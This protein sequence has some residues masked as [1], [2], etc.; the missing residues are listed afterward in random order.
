MEDDRLSHEA[1][2]FKYKL[3][4]YYQQTVMY[5]ITLI[6]YAGVR[7]TFTFERL[8]S[9]GADPLLYIIML[10]VII[11]IVG[12]VLNSAR[13]RKLII[14]KDKIIFHNKFHERSI[15]VSNIEWMHVGRERTVRTAG[16][17][18]IVIFKIKDRRR[19][20]RIRVGR[21]EREKELIAEMNR[22]AEQIPRPKRP[23]FGI[24]SQFA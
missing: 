14:D 18:Q 3:D 9:L 16:R 21:Y 19:W 7:G 12:L 17:S 22:I 1:K 24:R 6:L 4:F 10:F 23:L 8:P 20:F 13:D 2:I 15:P 11:S 5:L